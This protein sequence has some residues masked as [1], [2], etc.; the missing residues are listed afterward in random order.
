MN[1]VYVIE[2]YSSINVKSIMKIVFKSESVFISKCILL[3]NA[4]SNLKCY[5]K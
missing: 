5:S 2:C 4:E 3:L 1:L